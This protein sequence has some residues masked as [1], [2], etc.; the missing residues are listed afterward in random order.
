MPQVVHTHSKA[1]PGG[2]DGRL[3]DLV[4]EPVPGDVPVG[5]ERAGLPRVVLPERASPR[6]VDGVGAFAMTTPARPRRVTRERAVPVAAALLVRLR[7]AE[8]LRVGQDAQ[9]G[10]LAALVADREEEV[11]WAKLRTMAEGA[12]IASKQLWA[13]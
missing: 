5:V 11:V 3:P 13:K 10:L 1:Q 12:R 7:Q 8:F 9:V 2:F 6:A 4:A